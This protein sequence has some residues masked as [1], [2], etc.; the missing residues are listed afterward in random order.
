MDVSASLPSA[1]IPTGVARTFMVAL[2][3]A[4]FLLG[5][6]GGY[7]VRGWSPAASTTTTTHTTSHPFVPAP[8]P[9]SSPVP[10][11][12]PQ[13]PLDPSGFPIPI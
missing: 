8:V 7:L 1:R 12:A 10:S 3:A 2:L 4:V 11:P 13:P 6:T 9:Y 5:G